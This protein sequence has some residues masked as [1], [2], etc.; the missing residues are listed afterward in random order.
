MTSSYGNSKPPLPCH[1]GLLEQPP[2]QAA[3]CCVGF[4]PSSPPALPLPAHSVAPSHSS[5][6]SKP[7]ALPEDPVWTLTIFPPLGSWFPAQLQPAG[8][9]A[10]SRC[11]EAT[12]A[13]SPCRFAE[14]RSKVCVQFISPVPPQA[15][16]FPLHPQAHGHSL[17]SSLGI[18]HSSL[19]SWG[20]A[21]AEDRWLCCG[22][23]QTPQPSHWRDVVPQQDDSPVQTALTCI[24]MR[25]NNSSKGFFQTIK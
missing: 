7:K 13:V 3:L 17:S 23:V 21:I 19:T 6:P 10:V 16:L 5:Q 11:N 14:S 12:D 9:T 18:P 1:G 24:C 4:Y 25:D 20:V 15:R 8:S 22:T 2:Q